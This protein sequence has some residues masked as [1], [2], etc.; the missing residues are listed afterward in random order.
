MTT[1]RVTQNDK[2][3]DDFMAAKT[4]IDAMLE[5]LKALASRPSHN[6]A[7]AHPSRRLWLSASTSC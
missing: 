3:L 4:E 1:R 6:S 7:P 5:R 2:A